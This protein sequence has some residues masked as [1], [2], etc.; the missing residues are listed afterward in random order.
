MHMIAS[1]F[2]KLASV[3]TLLIVSGC[4]N[5]DLAQDVRDTEW[6]QKT[7]T[8]I[9]D[10]QGP[11]VEYL[12]EYLEKNSNTSDTT[13]ATYVGLFQLFGPKQLRDEQNGWK[14]I[15]SACANDNMRACRTLGRYA[16]RTPNNQEALSYGLRLLE[17]SCASGTT[18]A[19][20]DLSRI[21]GERTSELLPRN[22]SLQDE[23]RA[24]HYHGLICEAGNKSL[25]GVAHFHMRF[26]KISETR[27]YLK[28]HCD[29]EYPDICILLAR[30]HYDDDLPLQEPEKAVNILSSLCRIDYEGSCYHSMVAINDWKISP[31]DLNG[32]L[33]VAEKN[34]LAG[35]GDA[36]IPLAFFF[37]SNEDHQDLQ[38]AAVLNEHMCEMGRRHQCHMAARIYYDLYK[39]G[40]DIE[41]ARDRSHLLYS[42]LCPTE[43]AASQHWVCDRAFETSNQDLSA[44]QKV[45]LKCLMND[46]TAC[47]SG[48]WAAAKEKDLPLAL[49][50]LEYGCQLPN[51]SNMC[52]DL[53]TVQT[54]PEFGVNRDVSEAAKLLELACERGSQPGCAYL[55]RING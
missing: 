44:S 35:R 27:E 7:V 6:Q 40:I 21:Y 18:L 1:G 33:D 20:S 5:N 8:A 49:E 14:L 19:C 23:E 31:A 28:N 25:C 42:S 37:Y 29:E 54:S 10:R 3:I 41:H 46:V 15:Q 24:S 9:L 38:K 12:A 34:C 47:Y 30:T 48:G 43:D 4:G 50:L 2:T 17:K 53:F 22:V 11:K 51:G 36:C 26:F 16:T 55:E 39:A 32:V 52:V 45:R 13:T